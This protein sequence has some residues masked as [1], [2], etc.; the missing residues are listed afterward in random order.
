MG[1]LGPQPLGIGS[2]APP[3][4]GAV[5]EVRPVFQET[6][7]SE[8]ALSPPTSHRPPAPW[9][10]PRGQIV[11]GGSFGEPRKES[12]SQPPPNIDESENGAG[13]RSIVPARV[14]HPPQVSF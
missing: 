14:T 9:R 2:G 10:V 11:M 12:A 8:P 3:K 5:R 13:A 6:G 7:G 1:P 4:V